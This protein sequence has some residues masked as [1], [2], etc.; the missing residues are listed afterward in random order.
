MCAAVVLA[1]FVS[2]GVLDSMH[3]RPLLPPAKA[4]APAD[5]AEGG[6]GVAAVINPALMPPAP[7]RCLFI[8]RYCARPWTIYWR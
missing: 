7:M 5:A 2:L 8:H 4:A 1:G 6:A 3:Y